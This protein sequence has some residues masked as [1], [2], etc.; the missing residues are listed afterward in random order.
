[1]KTAKDIMI[2][3]VHTINS[4]SKIALARLK[5]L[6]HNIGGLPVADADGKLV[7]MITL[8]DIDLAG[9]D[10]SGLLVG[11][12][13]SQD[14]VTC[15]SDTDVKEIACRMVETGIQRIPVINDENKL[16]GLV[17]QTSIIKAAKDVF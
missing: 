9:S 5:M 7:G 4:D 15:R 10:I 13:M 17:T 3:N 11:E 6:R 14:L 2:K 16:L 12:L 8:R 1:M